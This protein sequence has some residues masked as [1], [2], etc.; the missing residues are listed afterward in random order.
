MPPRKTQLEAFITLLED[1]GAGHFT[2]HNLQATSGEEVQHT[3][4]LRFVERAL[5]HTKDR[6]DVLNC[7]LE[8]DRLSQAPMVQDFKSVLGQR[9]YSS[10]GQRAWYPRGFL[11]CCILRVMVRVWSMQEKKVTVTGPTRLLA[12]DL[13]NNFE[14]VCSKSLKSLMRAQAASPVT[15]GPSMLEALKSMR[16]LQQTV[17]ELSASKGVVDPV[18]AAL[19]QALAADDDEALFKVMTEAMN[20]TG[21]A[22]LHF[23]GTFARQGGASADAGEDEKACCE[24]AAEFGSLWLQATE[25][26][27]PKMKFGAVATCIFL[28]ESRFST[29]PS[30]AEAAAAEGNAS[31]DDEGPPHEVTHMEW[32]L[33]VLETARVYAGHTHAIVEALLLQVQQL[34]DVYGIEVELQNGAQVQ[35]TIT[36]WSKI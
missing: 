24:V 12:A 27:A 31:D 36:P 13:A 35:S 4:L 21:E 11:D 14:K 15:H 28:G 7:L 3:L 8:F 23:G 16:A 17:L 10:A 6:A 22:L 2:I 32:F 29:L 5:W 9:K 18:V 1:E 26:M 20:D 30:C 19:T 34:S 33:S 25:R